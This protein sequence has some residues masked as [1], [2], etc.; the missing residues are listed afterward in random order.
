M[1]TTGTTIVTI[2]ADNGSNVAL[3]VLALTINQPPAFT[4]VSS[5]SVQAG[6]PLFFQI[7]TNGF[8]TATLTETGTLPS[9]L[10][11][12]KGAG[13]TATLSGTVTAAPGDYQILLKASNKTL[14]DAIQ[15]FTIHVT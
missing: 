12:V 8:P 13:G 5:V 10:K 1:G 14:P 15:V 7:T 4:S 9:G 6:T 11:F 2:T 3:Q